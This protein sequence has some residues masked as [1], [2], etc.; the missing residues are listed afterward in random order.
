[1]TESTARVES[2]KVARHSAVLAVGN[3]VGLLLGFVT[4]ILVTDIL[5]DHYGLL[6]G[7]QRFVGLFLA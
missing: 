3:V 7:A 4:T 6:I 1:M 5:G 2:L